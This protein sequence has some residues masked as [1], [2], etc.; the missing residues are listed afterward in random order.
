MIGEPVINDEP[1]G[2]V[3]MFM[4]NLTVMFLFV[5]WMVLYDG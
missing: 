2:V 4:A 3:L 5:V 1:I